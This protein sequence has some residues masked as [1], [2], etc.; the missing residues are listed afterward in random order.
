MLT[1]MAYYPLRPIALAPLAFI[2]TPKATMAYSINLYYS[3]LCN[4]S[5]FLAFP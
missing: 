1:P 5:Y 3:Y 2:P 4:Y